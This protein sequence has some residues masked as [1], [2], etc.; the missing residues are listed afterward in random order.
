MRDEEKLGGWWWWKRLKN[1][2]KSQWIAIGLHVCVFYSFFHSDVWYGG[3]DI[4]D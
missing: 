3:N 1:N 4:A 2:I